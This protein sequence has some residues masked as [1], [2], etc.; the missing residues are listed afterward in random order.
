MATAAID[1]GARPIALVGL[2]G[3]GKTAVGRALARRLGR[4]F[5]DMDAVLAREAGMT[6]SALFA[7]HGETA[8]RRR[9]SRLLAR[10]ATRRDGPVVA[11]GGGVVLASANR[12]VLAR[13]FT[14]YWL[15]VGVERAWAR[16]GT[17]TGRPLLNTGDGSS[18]RERLRRIARERRGLYAACGA[19]VVTGAATPAA[20]AA[21]LAH[22]LVR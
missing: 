9:E 1:E 4:P 6:V 15:D 22:R 16:L 2:M 11:T 7:R 21:R 5:V 19:R 17:G 3:A 20:I 8:F 13:R 12:T 18:A 10:L 14:T